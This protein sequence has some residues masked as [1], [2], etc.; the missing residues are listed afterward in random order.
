[1][2][3]LLSWIGEVGFTNTLPR[4]GMETINEREPLCS[5]SFNGSAIAN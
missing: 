2:P 3:D 5:N 1:M 4:K